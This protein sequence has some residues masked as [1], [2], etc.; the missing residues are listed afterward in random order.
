LVICSALFNSANICTVRLGYLALSI[1]ARNVPTISKKTHSG[2]TT[3][4]DRFKLKKQFTAIGDA[5]NVAARLE[6]ETKNREAH[7]LISDL[8]PGH[9]Y[10][11]P[12]RLP[13]PL[14]VR[15]FFI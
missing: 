3:S 2:R 11:P 12:P 13:H 8:S 6:S 5:V 10:E 15:G 4:P 1:P 9:G 14:P 7:I